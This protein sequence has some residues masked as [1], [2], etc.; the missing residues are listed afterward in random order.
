[1]QRGSVGLSLGLAS[2]AARAGGAD[3]TGEES[4]SLDPVQRGS[5]VGLSYRAASDACVGAGWRRADL[6]RLQC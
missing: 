5:V 2:S 4:G 6:E 3:L 1:M